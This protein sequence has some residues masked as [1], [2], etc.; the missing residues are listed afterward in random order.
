[1]A[2][3]SFRAKRAE[4]LEREGFAGERVDLVTERGAELRND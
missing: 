4:L 2:E 3:P 1:M